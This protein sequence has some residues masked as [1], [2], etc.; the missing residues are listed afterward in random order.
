MSSLWLRIMEFCAELQDKGIL[1]VSE[2]RMPEKAELAGLS[3]GLESWMKY[4][5]SYRQQSQYVV[6]C[7]KVIQNIL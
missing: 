3:D 2:E 6:F 4:T 5:L 1:C 7:R